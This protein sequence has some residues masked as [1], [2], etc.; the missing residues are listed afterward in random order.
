MDLKKLLETT[1]ETLAQQQYGMLTQAVVSR[2]G[3]LQGHIA[4]GELVAA[5]S[6]LFNSPAGDD[7]GWDNACVEFTDLLAVKGYENTDRGVDISDV[8][9]RLAALQKIISNDRRAPHVPGV[10]YK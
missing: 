9:D 3:T 6:M 10:P 1:P 4:R 5:Q 2:L 8:I 7:H